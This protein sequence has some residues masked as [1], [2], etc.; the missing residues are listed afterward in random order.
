MKKGKAKLASDARVG[1]SGFD[2]VR[3][4]RSLALFAG[5]FEHVWR[6]GI[7]NA[8]KVDLQGCRLLQDT[9]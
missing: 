5:V 4:A 7:G 1:K 9:D 2:Q 3:A 8:R 6:G